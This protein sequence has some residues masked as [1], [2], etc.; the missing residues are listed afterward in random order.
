MS[1]RAEP[2]G[3]RLSCDYDSVMKGVKNR[4]TAPMMKVRRFRIAPP[5]H[6]LSF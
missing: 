6:A 2:I 5:P 4:P 1:A 3:A